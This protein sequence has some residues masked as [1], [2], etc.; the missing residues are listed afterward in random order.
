MRVDNVYKA[1][2]ALLQKSSLLPSQAISMLSICDAETWKGLPLLWRGQEA[3]QIGVIKSLLDEIPKDSYR[4]SGGLE[5]AM[6]DVEK[7]ADIYR[8]ID[9]SSPIKELVQWATLHP[10]IA[11]LL[12]ATCNAW[13][14][15]VTNIFDEVVGAMLC[16]P[17][18][19]Q[20]RDEFLTFVRI[21]PLLV[22]IVVPQNQNVIFKEAIRR[23][24]LS[25]YSQC[26]IYYSRRCILKP[27]VTFAKW[28]LDFSSNDHPL[29]PDSP[30]TPGWRSMTSS[31]VRSA[32]V[33]SNKYSLISI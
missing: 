16:Y 19:L 11:S 30:K 10:D 2:S 28:E 7:V 18:H 6:H 23:I 12:S 5:W 25:G 1:Y 27:V 15:A 17:L 14:F 21:V 4:L 8:K 24:N 32:M 31:D 33:L 29:L 9:Y 13:S 20:I 26:L 22:G 3:E